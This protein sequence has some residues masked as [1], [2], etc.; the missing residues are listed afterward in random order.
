V[1]L[2]RSDAFA[3]A[4]Q[5]ATQCGCIEISILVRTVLGTHILLYYFYEE[6]VPLARAAAIRKA[7]G[8]PQRRR[9]A[10]PVSSAHHSLMSL[11]TIVHSYIRVNDELP[12]HE[13]VFFL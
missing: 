6:N 13:A 7:C 9:V 5:A 10:A 11:D 4:S 12:N 8:T 3:A 2:A 1:T